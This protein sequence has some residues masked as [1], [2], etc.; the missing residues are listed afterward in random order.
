LGW[1]AGVCAF[2]LVLGSSAKVAAQS[3]KASPSVTAALDRLGGNGGLAK[4]YLGLSFIL[5]AVLV[6][7]IAASQVAAA[8]NEEASGRAEHLLVRPVSRGRF[9]L[10]RLAVGA[11]A[12]VAAGA[13]G[14]VSAWLGAAA[15]H[16]G[17]EFSSTLGA[18]LNTVSAGVCLLG[19]GAL[20]WAV[21]PRLTSA[22]VY[23][24]VAWGFLVELLGGLVNSNRWLLDTSIF[25][26]LAPA[27]AEA[28]DWTSGGAMVALGI[29][30]ALVGAVLFTR[31]DLVGD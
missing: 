5:I 27:P 25:H 30:G 24:V 28:P 26:Q 3:L 16:T 1:L 29:V 18:G 13:L 4:A 11:A 17:L 7:L 20:A 2:G 12:V 23:G 10:T 15:Q 9:M 21:V 31:R 14:G 6:V 22:A 8:R 19:I